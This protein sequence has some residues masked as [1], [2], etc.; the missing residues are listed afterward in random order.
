MN[1]LFKR[2]TPR[3]VDLTYEWQEQ[4]FKTDKDKGKD[5]E[6]DR[7][8]GPLA[9]GKDSMMQV[10]GSSLSRSHLRLSFQAAF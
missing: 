8:N 7:N 10:L 6:S 3:N 1:F 5:R 4:V 2:Q 9:N